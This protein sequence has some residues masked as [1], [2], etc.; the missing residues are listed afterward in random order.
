MHTWGVGR[1]MRSVYT[2]GSPSVESGEVGL[3]GEMKE[4]EYN[5]QSLKTIDLIKSNCISMCKALQ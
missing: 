5:R 2:S 4:G 1:D 3:R